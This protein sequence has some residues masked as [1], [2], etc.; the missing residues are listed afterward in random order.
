MK[1]L[2]TDFEF[3]KVS[4]KKITEK[5]SIKE[6]VNPFWIPKCELDK[7]IWKNFSKDCENEGLYMLTRSEFSED[8]ILESENSHP[9]CKSCLEKFKRIAKS[10]D[11]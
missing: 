11:K 2:K 6:Q 3:K 4:Y 7:N 10:I 1:K 9:I 8:N 5:F